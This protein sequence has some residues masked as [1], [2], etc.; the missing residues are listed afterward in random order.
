MASQL[1]SSTGHAQRYKGY[2][3]NSAAP[4]DGE[5]KCHHTLL[6]ITDRRNAPSKPS[7]NDDSEPE[8][9]NLT[10]IAE[11]KKTVIDNRNIL[12]AQMASLEGR[13]V[14]FSPAEQLKALQTNIDGRV[15][16]L[17]ARI[18]GLDAKMAEIEALL[19]QVLRKL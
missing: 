1:D 7:W 16:A 9:E 10:T 2:S 11:V 6:R 8:D 17:E 5:H 14:K 12:T 4:Q 13:L 3:Q 15:D 19:R 18:S